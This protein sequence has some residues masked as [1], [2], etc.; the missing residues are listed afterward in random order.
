MI[1]FL[2][3]GAVGF[4]LAHIFSSSTIKEVFGS[5]T[6]NRSRPFKY[7]VVGWYF[8]ITSILGIWSLWQRVR[9]GPP[10]MMEFGSVL[11]GWSALVVMSS[12]AAVQLFLGSGLLRGK[13]QSRRFTIYYLLFECLDVLVFFL[14]PGRDARI[15]AYYDMLA[16]VRPTFNMYLSTA[17]WSRYMKTA[18]IEWAIFALV[19]AWFLA[20]QNNSSIPAKS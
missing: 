11:V 18:S 3:S 20:R 14:R 13:E 4:W 7:S 1:M 10:V 8:V 9:H 16:A 6:T 19:M 12:Y 15:G 5:S 2:L 17:S